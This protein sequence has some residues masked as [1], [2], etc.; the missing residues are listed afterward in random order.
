MATGDQAQILFVSTEHVLSLICHTCWQCWRQH[1]LRPVSLSKDSSSSKRTTAES[2]WLHVSPTKSPAKFCLWNS[3]GW[4]WSG[5]QEKGSFIFRSQL[6]AAGLRGRGSISWLI[7]GGIYG[8][9]VI[10]TTW[11]WKGTVTF[12]L[13]TVQNSSTHEVYFSVHSYSHCGLREKAVTWKPPT[14]CLTYPWFVPHSFRMQR[15]LWTGS[16][17]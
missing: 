3:R 2:V 4:R 9:D 17:M 15:C 7:N 10:G 12:L 1:V 16:F 6:E 5:K 14:C 13:Q 8:M 11:L